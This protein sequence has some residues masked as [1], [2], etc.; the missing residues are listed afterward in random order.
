MTTRLKTVVEV[1]TP[2]TAQKYL[3]MNINRNRKISK[4][5]VSRLAATMVSGE[6][7]LNG[8]AIRFNKNGK[9]IDGQT[10][11]AAIVHCKKPLESVVIRGL[12][13]RAMDTIDIGKPRSGGDFLSMHGYQGAV[14]ALAAAISITTAFDSKGVYNNKKGKASPRQMLDYL[15]KNKRM[16]KSYEIFTAAKEK[17]FQ[18]LLPQSIAIACH[19]MFCEIDKDA[20]ESFFHH[21]VKGVNLGAKSPILKLRTELIG[22]RSDSK[23]A[24]TT[25]HAFL[26]YLTKAFDLYLHDKRVDRLPEYKRAEIITLPKV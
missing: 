20:G 21:L 16:L 11:L 15:Q 24:Y 26:F 17:E 13:E 9:L 10:R 22:M 2:K 5:R 1:I 14:Y 7:V 18:Q 12:D 4:S 23:R 6:W 19:Y 3:S 8:D 25:R